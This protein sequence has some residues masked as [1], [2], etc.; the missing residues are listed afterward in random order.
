L[1]A[2]TVLVVLNVNCRVW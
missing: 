1:T 2:D